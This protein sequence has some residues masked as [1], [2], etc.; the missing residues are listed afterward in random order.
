MYL[1]VSLLFYFI[2]LCYGD[3]DVTRLYFKNEKVGTLHCEQG[4]ASKWSKDGNLI[5]LDESGFNITDTML[6][7]NSFSS[8]Y[9]GSYSCETTTGSILKFKVLSAANV[10]AFQSKSKNLVEG[11]DLELKCGASGVDTV[12]W[13]KDNKSLDGN[14][15][16]TYEE[17][18]SI[19]N[20]K[21]KVEKLEFED[22]GNYSCSAGSDTKSII[23]RVKDK[24]AALYPFIGIVCEVAFFCALIVIYERRRAKKMSEDDPPEEAGHL[25]NSK[26]H[27]DVEVR[28]RK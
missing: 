8:E 23:V 17:F 1:Y 24:L 27:N 25:T 28:Q 5:S 22:A 19:S 18:N 20:G 21:L 3:S 10:T 2:I 14:M 9:I 7:I 4:V 15:R 11:D 26:E 16:V 12:F 6:V 13:L